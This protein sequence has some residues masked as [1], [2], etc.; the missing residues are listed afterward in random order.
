MEQKFSQVFDIN[1][2]LKLNKNQKIDFVE[3]KDIEPGK[4]SVVSKYKKEF[5]GSGSKFERGDTLFARITPCL[6]NGKI[7]RYDGP[8]IA[9]GSTE[10]IVIR[11][12]EGVTLSN[13][14]YYYSTWEKFREFCIQNMIGS[15]GRQRVPVDALDNWT[16]SLPSLPEQK[17]IVDLLNSLDSKIELNQKMNETL[18]EIAKTLFRS[19]F[20]DFDPVR[21]KVEK[22]P[23]GL[24]KEISDLFPDCFEDSELGEIPKGWNVKKISDIFEVKKGSTPA[25]KNSEFWEPK[26]HIWVSP[27]DLSQNPYVYLFHSGRGISEIGLQKTRSGLLPEN[28]VMMSSRAPIGLLGISGANVALGTGIFAIPPKKIMSSGLT[29]FFVDDQI[30]KLKQLSIGTTFEEDSLKIFN[31]LMIVFPNDE[32]LIGTKDI[33]DNLFKKIKNNTL[34]IKSLIDIRDTLLPKLISSELKITNA[35]NLIE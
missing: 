6:E 33:F 5:K 17:K 20:I 28:T 27:R 19:W 26:E 10:F 13:F 31:N 18:E 34:E 22:R 4:R 24:S 12:K 11:G 30:R 7:S 23:T 9:F 2:K 14:A 1:P 25:T 35:A 16:V 3:M 8:G 29:Y 32:V 15:S 21:A